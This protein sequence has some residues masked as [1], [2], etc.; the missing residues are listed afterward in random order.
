[1]LRLYEFT[2]LR[3]YRLWLHDFTNLP[4][5]GF[6]ASGSTTLRIY[7]FTVLPPLAPQLYEFTVLRFYRLWRHN[8]T[9]LPFYGF[10]ASGSSR[11]TTLMHDAFTNLPFYGFTVFCSRCS[12]KKHQF[13]TLRFYL[14]FLRF[15]LLHGSHLLYSF[16]LLR[17]YYS[18]RFVSLSFR[19]LTMMF[20]SRRA[21]ST[22]FTQ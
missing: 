10:T 19:T 13:T 21:A 20:S 3:F 4:F 9:N 12:R 5:Y 6:T 17:L 15:H 22:W 11:S 16:T 18:C 8:F 7:R 2:V 1:M 14:G